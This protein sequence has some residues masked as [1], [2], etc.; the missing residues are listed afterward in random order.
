M[1][2]FQASANLSTYAIPRVVRNYVNSIELFPAERRLMGQYKSQFRGDVLD[3]AIGGG[4]T[5]RAL[6]P[7]S[8]SYIGID[9]AAGMVE[10]AKAEF[11]QAD[12]RCLD[13]RQVPAALSRER[14]DAILISFNGID[15]ISW[16][17]RNTLL[18]SLHG[19]LHPGGAL[20]FSTHDLAAAETESRFRIRSDLQLR[21]GLLVRQPSEFVR[22][23]I[24]MPVW[25]ALAL[26]NRRRMRKQVAFFDG[27]A[28]LNDS[29]ENFGL[30]TTYTATDLQVNVLE[31]A[32]YKHIEVLQPWLASEPASFN[33]FGCTA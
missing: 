12:L 22:R 17:E 25:C 20:V 27:Y 31:D 32:G 30:L 24:K 16:E 13:M 29:G 23:L 28:Y 18:G 4:R 10:A 9:Y 7:H 21:P 6:L 19:M 5:T 15:Y 1:S 33:Y 3:I 14:F 26:R 8:K 2:A 11:P